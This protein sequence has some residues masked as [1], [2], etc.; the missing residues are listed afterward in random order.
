[1]PYLIEKLPEHEFERIYRDAESNP[2]LLR[3]MK[4]RGGILENNYLANWAIN[5]DRTSYICSGPREPRSAGRSVCFFW[6]GN[7]YQFE[8][9]TLW[10]SEVSISKNSLA[11]P[12]L[13]KEGRAAAIEALRVYGPIGGDI[14]KDF[15]PSIVGGEENGN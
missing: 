8:F 13:G 4:A 14:A 2:D 3:Y 11:L 10:V 7:M 1:M 15:S 12:P 5:S 6:R 9:E